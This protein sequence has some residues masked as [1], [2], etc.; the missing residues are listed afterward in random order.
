[1]KLTFISKI[2]ITCAIIGMM[3]IV[4]GFLTTAN[5]VDWGGCG[6]LIGHIFRYA[7]PYMITCEAIIAVG[8]IFLYRNGDMFE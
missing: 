4:I 3:G 6:V 1:M 5:V 8:F 7:A 2:M